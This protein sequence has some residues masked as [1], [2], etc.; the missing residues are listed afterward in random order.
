M[1]SFLI[2]LYNKSY[3]PDIV[4]VTAVLLLGWYLGLREEPVPAEDLQAFS[5]TSPC[6]AQAVSEQL[7]RYAKIV[8]KKDL[9]AVE[10]RCDRLTAPYKIEAIKAAAVAKTLEAQRAILQ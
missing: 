4:V 8:L 3:F 9:G 6:Q 5:Q 1:K 10:G 2:K 7:N